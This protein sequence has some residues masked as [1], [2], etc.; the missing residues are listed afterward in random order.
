[1]IAFGWVIR[2]CSLYCQGRVHYVFRINTQRL[3]T[4]QSTCCILVCIKHYCHDLLE[5]AQRPQ[6]IATRGVA[7]AWLIWLC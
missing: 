6:L 2:S 1:M 5:V 7:P 3:F 4:R